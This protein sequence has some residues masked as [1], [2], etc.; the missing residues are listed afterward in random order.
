M[1]CD[2]CGAQ[3]IRGSRYC[4]SCGGGLPYQS[5]CPVLDS[6]KS[7][8]GIGVLGI[9]CWL[10]VGGVA[11]FLGGR[12]ESIILGD[13]IAIVY[14]IFQFNYLFRVFPSYFTSKPK[15]T[16]NEKISFLNFFFGGLI[17]GWFLQ[18]NLNKKKKGVAHIVYAILIGL[19]IVASSLG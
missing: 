3:N 18:N 10:L 14:V 11:D 9:V 5:G 6:W 15:V 12:E 4:C 1:Y 8:I 13:V 16:E 2:K 17:A 19:Y 7:H